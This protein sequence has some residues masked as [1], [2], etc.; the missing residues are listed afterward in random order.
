MIMGLLLGLF[1]SVIRSL[2]GRGPRARFAP[3]C[4]FI[5]GLFDLIIGLILGLF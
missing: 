5:L 1:L 2:L 4:V 3:V